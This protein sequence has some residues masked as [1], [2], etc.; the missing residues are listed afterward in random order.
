MASVLSLTQDIPAKLKPVATRSLPRKVWRAPN[1]VADIILVPRIRCPTSLVATYA[2]L[3]QLTHSLYHIRT[4]GLQA[5]RNHTFLKSCARIYILDIIVCGFGVHKA[6]KSSRPPAR[7]NENRASPLIIKNAVT[8]SVAAA[9]VGQNTD[10]LKTSAT[11]ILKP[12]VGAAAARCIALT[13]S[14]HLLK[15][16]M[17]AS[18]EECG[19]WP[20]RLEL[21]P[22]IGS[23]EP[24]ERATGQVRN[25]R[26]R[27]I[28]ST[29]RSHQHQSGE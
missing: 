18:M 3:W 4:V 16:T 28:S 10:L 19:I 21:L 7:F 1:D 15:R 12:S 11:G 13:E 20:R 9:A 27:I 8:A 14:P 29:L 2:V 23:L 5:E 22:V 17:S 6:R 26:G 24:S 25:L